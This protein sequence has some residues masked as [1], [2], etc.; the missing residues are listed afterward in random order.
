MRLR[1]FLV[2]DHLRSEC[3]LEKHTPEIFPDHFLGYIKSC[4]AD[5]S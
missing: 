4:V 1:Y 3:S 5:S 2:N